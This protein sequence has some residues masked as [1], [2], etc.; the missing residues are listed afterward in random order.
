MCLLLSTS[1]SSG[2]S[3]QVVLSYGNLE[4]SCQSICA[5]LPILPT[6]VTITTL[7]FQYSYGLS[8]IN[9]HLATGAA[10]IL[11]ELSFIQR[12][13]WDYFHEHKVTSSEK[14][15]LKWFL[16]LYSLLNEDTSLWSKLK[17]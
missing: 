16:E 17:S 15:N 2:E 10:I 3:K 4:A 5:Y 8:I 12:E 1:S 11:T 14:N 13:F 7:P 6:D 9:T